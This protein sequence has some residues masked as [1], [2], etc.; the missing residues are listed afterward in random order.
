[1]LIL[2]AGD[3]GVVAP[4]GIRAARR[5][6]AD[7]DDLQVPGGVRGRR[8]RLPQPRRR[9]CGEHEPFVGHLQDVG[10]A[11]GVL[12]QA[13]LELEQ[14]RVERRQQVVVGQ[15]G[16]DAIE[17]GELGCALSGRNLPRVRL[18]R[19][20]DGELIRDRERADPEA[21]ECRRPSA[22][23]ARFP[24]LARRDEKVAA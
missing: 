8:L 7:A 11:A 15:P 9:A 20:Q 1:M 18:R 12:R 21:V 23:A 6:I 16:E 19:A 4:A 24:S 2:L 10:S 14:D 3:T 5:P 13:L 17:V 22:R